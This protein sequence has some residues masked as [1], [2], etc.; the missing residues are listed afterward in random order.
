VKEVRT[1]GILSDRKPSQINRILTEQKLDDI[2]HRFEDSPRKSLRPLAR[3][4]SVC[5][6]WTATKLSHIR[7]YKITVVP[8]I[9]PLDYEKRVTFFTDEAN[10]NLLGYVN[11]PNNSTGVVK[12][13]MP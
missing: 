9:K 4:C 6:A 1:H 13:L 5:R 3:Q 7:P 12:I 11:S 10:F 8:E 2:G